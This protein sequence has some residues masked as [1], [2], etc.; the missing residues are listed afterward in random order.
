MKNAQASRNK[1]HKDL[2]AERGLRTVSVVVPVERID[3]LKAIAR[4]M[5][6]QSVNTQG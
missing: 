2:N 4:K 1:R 5:R 6:E 3:E